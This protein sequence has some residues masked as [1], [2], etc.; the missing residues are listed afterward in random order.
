ME[1]PARARH[2]PVWSLPLGF[3]AL[4]ALL[5]CLEMGNDTARWMC[6]AVF[7]A[8]VCQV[9][10]GHRSLVQQV[11]GWLIAVVIAYA[12]GN[13]MLVFLMLVLTFMQ[14][15]AFD[16]EVRP[17]WA[18]IAAAFV[19]ALGLLALDHQRVA[20]ESGERISQLNEMLGYLTGRG[21]PD[22]LGDHLAAEIGD[23]RHPDRLWWVMP[24]VV[25]GPLLLRRFA[26]PHLA[27]LIRRREARRWRG[28][29]FRRPLDLT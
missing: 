6:V 13:R 25:G 11:F 10:L 26:S 14:A 7:V 2:L 22:G 12:A 20:T 23:L 15:G 5:V 27:A 21:D 3:G 16:L 19:T 8:T 24:F 28:A 18:L 1:L 17:R 9:L 29:W 4:A